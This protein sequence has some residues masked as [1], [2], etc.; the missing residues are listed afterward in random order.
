MFDSEQTET[1]PLARADSDLI[2]ASST[3][4]IR[5]FAR[6]RSGQP[7][8]EQAAS[9]DFDFLFPLVFESGSAKKMCYSFFPALQGSKGLVVVFHGYLGFEIDQLRY[10]WKDFDLLMPLDN[11]GWK[12]LGGWFW[13]EGGK[14]DVELITQELIEHIRLERGNQRWFSIGASMGGFAALFHGIKYAA[15]GIYVMTPILD[16]KGKIRD[17]RSREIRTSY[18]EVAAAHD[19][20]LKDVPDIYFEAQQAKDLPPLYLIQNQYDRANPFGRDTLPLL[21]L[22]EAKKGWLGLRIQP[23]IGHQG[24]DGSYNEAQYFFK[25]IA[26]KS[27]PRVVDFYD[28]E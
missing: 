2:F 17:Y 27:P 16:L 20:E 22:Y 19:T 13:G 6:R 14:N 21:S 10:S 3:N 24:H 26:T 11:F 5:D 8:K 18:T 28:Q 4:A 12:N 23:A 15:D 9:R 1:F 7:K 25:L